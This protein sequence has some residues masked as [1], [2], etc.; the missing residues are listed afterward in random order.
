MSETARLGPAG[1]EVHKAASPPVAFDAFFEQEGD[2]LYRALW[3]VTRNRFHAEVTPE[4]FVRLRERWD[5]A[6][7]MADLGLT[8]DGQNHS[9]ELR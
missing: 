8:L 4:A 9:G 3:L 2:G 7:V 5:R 1:M 6:T